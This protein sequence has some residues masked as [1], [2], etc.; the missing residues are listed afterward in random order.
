MPRGFFFDNTRCT[1]CR[2]CVLAC[3]DYHDH[4]TDN[5]FRMVI[6]YE[7][8]SWTPGGSADS[9]GAGKGQPEAHGVFAYHISLA[10]N[11]CNNPVCTQVCPTGAMHKDDYDLVWPDVRKCIGC[12]YCT[13]ACPY[14]APHIDAHLKRSSK[15]DG[16]RDRVVE[17]KRPVCV[18]ACPVRALEFGRASE[19]Q[20]RHPN[21]VRSI[22]PLPPENA[23][24]PNLYILP[25]PAALRTDVGE[26]HIANR[27]EIGL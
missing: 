22:M 25:S 3:K 12:G 24:S 21:A 23:T 20:E 13:M 15:C 26:G 18:E 1:G 9:A 4:G 19:L 8:G 2:T 6:D 11:H 5:A 14:H 17:G 16:C 10:C 27:K 7:G